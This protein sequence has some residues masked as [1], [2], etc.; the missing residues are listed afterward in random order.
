MEFQEFRNEL[1]RRVNELL[2]S[3]ISAIYQQVQ[4]NNNVFYTGLMLDLQEER[5]VSAVLYA[6]QLFECFQSGE[7]LEHIA[8]NVKNTFMDQKTPWP[9]EEIYTYE[10][11][12]DRVIY[13]L[14]GAEQNRERLTHEPH[15]RVLDMALCY[16]ILFE[17]ESEAEGLL[18]IT[19]EL[20]T[21]WGITEEML[22]A[23]AME[24]TVRL[25]GEEMGQLSDFCGEEET[26][27][28]KPLRVL[29]NRHEF[30]GATAVLYS[31]K[32][33]EYAET[34]ESNLYVIPISVHEMVV[35]PRMPEEC[36]GLR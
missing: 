31:K 12:R 18:S 34:I 13:R 30:F 11:V 6:E 14:V 5:G 8:E 24:N 22:Y 25:M 7:A 29:T 28:T 32:L 9:F 35:L 33:R 19:D 4:K 16:A 26:E 3:G 23:R 15:R 1:L 21:E 27:R 10:K 20:L 36:D 2:P 17:K